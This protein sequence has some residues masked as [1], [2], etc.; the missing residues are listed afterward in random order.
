MCTYGVALRRIHTGPMNGL[1]K[2]QRLFVGFHLPVYTQH[3]PKPIDL[4]VATG[5]AKL[6]TFLTVRSQ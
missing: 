1:D 3:Y 2:R 4:S 6:I 5:V